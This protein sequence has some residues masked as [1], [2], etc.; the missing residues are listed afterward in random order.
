MYSGQEEPFLD[1]IRFF[2]KDTIT[3][4]KFQRAPFYKTLLHLRMDNP[5]LAAN[6]PFSKLRTDKDS[7]IYAYERGTGNNK[8]LVILNLSGS[9]QAFNW[10][11]QPSE[12]QWNNVFGGNPETIQSS[13]TMQPWAFAV[14]EL[15]K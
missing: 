13:L 6:A 14:F 9:Q 8:V 4:S 5:A 15:R 12:K 2:Y 11:D 10:V 3:F 7:S 1:S